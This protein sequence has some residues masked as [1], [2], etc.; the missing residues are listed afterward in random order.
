M[1][2]AWKFNSARQIVF[3]NGVIQRLPALIRSLGGSQHLVSSLISQSD[4]RRRVGC[5]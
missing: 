5:A 2:D 3:G 1:Q 4:Q